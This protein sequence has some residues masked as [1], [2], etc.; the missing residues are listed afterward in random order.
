MDKAMQKDLLTQDWASSEWK[1]ILGGHWGAGTFDLFPG[2]GE[3]C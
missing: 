3:M 2:S 1:V